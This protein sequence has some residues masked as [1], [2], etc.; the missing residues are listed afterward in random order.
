MALSQH[1]MAGDYK[2]AL[3]YAQEAVF[4]AKEDG[5]HALQMRAYK[6]MASVEFYTG[7]FDQAILHF[8]R[9]AEQAR[10]SGDEIEALNN[11]F[12]IVLINIAMADYQKCL[13][14]M[15]ELRPKLADAYR[16]AGRSWPLADQVSIHLNMGVAQLGLGDA[17]RAQQS[18]DSAIALMGS[19]AD[20]TGTL[21]KLLLAKG[22]ASISEGNTSEALR[23]FDQAE[24][25]LPKEGDPAR[26]ILLEEARLMAYEQKG[27]LSM[28]MRVAR[29]GLSSAN[30]VGS[31]QTAKAFAEALSRI[32]RKTGPADSAIR[33]LDMV[34]KYEREAQSGRV[35]EEMMRKELKQEFEKKERELTERESLSGR[36]QVY[37]IMVFVVLSLVSVVGGLYYRRRYRQIRLNDARRE[38][39]SRRLQLESQRLQA[40]LNQRETELEQINTRIRNNEL[41]ESLVRNQQAG[42]AEAADKEQA[43]PPTEKFYT[44]GQG[45]K[46]WQ[47]FEYRFL[48][49]HTGFYERLA[50]AHPDLT[51]NERRLCTF[52]K[53]DMT[54]KEIAVITGQTLRAIEIARIRLRKKLNLTQ[55]STSLYEYFSRL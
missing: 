4:A 30:I 28:G 5:D 36:N 27:D 6:S 35:R 41:I 26:W 19:G 3:G 44:P 15:E 34:A 43:S 31:I 11:Q 52:L 18:L 16:K 32:Y 12:N 38:L 48:Q 14:G 50:A 7:L 51:L 29:E 20:P 47:E 25:Q 17:Q 42:N 45:T 55:S 21:F 54:T 1:S 46:G 33:Y 8:D 23:F 13:Q 37:T 9:A 53:L 24:G 39:E 40:E 49:M 10:Q 2:K 22:K